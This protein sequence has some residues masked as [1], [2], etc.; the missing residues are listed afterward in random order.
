MPKNKIAITIERDLL[1]RL[2]QLVEGNLYP[3]RSAAIQD[4]VS[5]KVVRLEKT[6]LARE[7]TRLDKAY[8]Q[9][10]AEEVLASE[11]VEWDEY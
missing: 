6:R 8:E 1:A 10:L 2:D 9:E 11:T 5:E 3:S 7:C 4:A